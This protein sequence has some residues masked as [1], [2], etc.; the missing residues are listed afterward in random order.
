MHNLKQDYYRCVVHYKL[1]PPG[2][3]ITKEYYLSVMLCCV[4]TNRVK[5]PELWAQN[6]WFLYHDNAPYHTALTHI[7]LQP[8]YLFDMA[9]CDFWLFRKLTRAV[10]IKQ[11]YE[12]KN[13]I[14]KVFKTGKRWLKKH[15]T[16]KAKNQLACFFF[17]R[18]DLLILSINTSPYRNWNA[19]A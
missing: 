3:S 18:E 2:Q 13:R 6:Y 5:L 12:N 14:E 4:E 16:L 15:A 1:H 19:V 9:P 10:H 11:Y 7:V 8:S 17:I